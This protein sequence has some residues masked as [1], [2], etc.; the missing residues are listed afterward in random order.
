MRLIYPPPI[1]AYIVAFMLLLCTV[2]F[3]K[4][5][6]LPAALKGGTSIDLPL[7]VLGKVKTLHCHESMKV[8][9]TRAFACIKKHASYIKTTA[10]C[11]CYRYIGGTVKLSQHAFGLAVDLDVGLPPNPI[12]VMCLEA[13]GFEWG[14]RWSAPKTDN[15]HFQLKESI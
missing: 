1:Y 15:M 14:G 2:T 6:C 4:D 9:L 12:V 3:A 10:G 7:G 13:S 8:P 5:L 11:Y